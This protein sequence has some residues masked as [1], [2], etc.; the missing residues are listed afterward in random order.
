M[1]A[2]RAIDLAIE[3]H[4]NG[5][6]AEADLAYRQI[7]EIDPKDFDARHLL[8][9]VRYQQNRSEEARDLIRSA[10]EINPDSLEALSNYGSVLNA[11]GQFADAVAVLDRAI[12]LQSKHAMAHYNRGNA[13]RAL[14]RPK[15]A[16]TSY[17]NALEINPEYAEAFSSRGLALADIQRFGL[18]ISSY[19]KALAIKPDFAEAANNRGNSFRALRRLDEALASYDLALTI[20]PRYADAWN[21]RGN[22]LDDLSRHDEAL[23]SF[24]E[25]L[26]NNPNLA[27]AYFGRGVVLETL[28]HFDEAR[29]SYKQS[30]AIAPHLS[31][32]YLNYASCTKIDAADPHFKTMLELRSRDQTLDDLG[33]I[34]LD[35]AL[36]KAH[37]DLNN[38]DLS[39]THLSRGN[40][41]KRA[42]LYYDEADIA[43]RLARIKSVFTP[44]FIRSRERVGNEAGP[45]PIFIFGMPRSGTTLVEQILA[46]HPKVFGA[47]ELKQ[48]NAI[49][50]EFRK[51]GGVPLYYPDY[52]PGLEPSALGAMGAQYKAELRKLAPDAQYVT[53]KML[54]NYQFA[55][56]IHL[57][58]SNARMVH[59]T[60]NP[61]DNCFSCY[62]Q[63]FNEGHEYTYDLAEL[64]RYYSL[65]N[66][67]MAHWSRVL[68]KGRILTVRYENIVTDLE[69]EAKRIVAHCGLAWNAQCLS[70]YK[71]ARPVRTASATQVRRPIYDTAVGRSHL[72]DKYLGPLKVQLGRV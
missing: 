60:R 46:S 67:L 19:D 9:V 10:L 58:L 18:A 43:G 23:A 28:G 2:R 31:K 22:V 71:S 15:E 53:D 6:M 70:F 33:R 64:G 20:K 30:L 8:G 38:F 52:V 5:Q 3:K 41:L 68:P 48:F 32:T 62:T 34:H 51:P 35:F 26:T 14:R 29:E 25:A 12:A 45:V 63:L 44:A 16:L 13:L 42:Q 47:G 39:F 54:S 37:A 40:D 55:G 21:N 57:V 11:L 4:R 72:F 59:V 1:N 69:G 24:D 36:A 65:Y 27:E 7:L 49:V 61:I 50:A 17:D 66:D 56:L